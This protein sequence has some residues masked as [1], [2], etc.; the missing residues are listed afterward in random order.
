MRVAIGAVTAIVI[1][2]TL[3]FRAF[4]LSWLDSV[5][6]TIISIT[7]VGYREIGTGPVDDPLTTA[8][9]VFTMG[10][11]VVGVSTA[12]YT[13]TLVVQTVVEGQ[14]REF[15]GRRRMDKKIGQMAGHT[16]VCGWGRVGSAVATDLAEAGAEIVVI[17]G[18][19]DRVSSIPFRTILGDAT[20]DAVLKAAGI[21]RAKSLI[22]AIDTDAANLFVTLSGRDLNP[23]LF[24]VARARSDESVPKLEHAGADR[25][26]NPQEIGAARMAAFV[27]RPSVAEFID[28]V[29]HERDHDFHMEEFAITGSSL[30][31]GQTIS[32][33]HIRERSGAL[34]LALRS[35]EGRFI[36]NPTGDTVLEPGHLVI[37][38]G[39]T[40]DFARLREAG[41][42]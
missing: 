8:E 36:T 1:V 11:I 33:A 16:I 24:I 25:V 34:I 4:G 37:A 40:E 7:T 6:M 15:V 22:A 2:G 29:M 26:V 27:A 5:Y 41:I 18:N 23:D 20:Q 19:P 12:L 14:F 10:L 30:L 35:P 3:G 21:D 9:K 38:V 39:T 32:G 28:V 42:S 31:A 17:D 13:F